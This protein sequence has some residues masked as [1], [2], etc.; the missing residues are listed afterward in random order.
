MHD[1]WCYNADEMYDP[2]LAERYRYLRETEEGREIM[3]KLVED[4]VKEACK[5]TAERVE[6][7]T[8]VR[9]AKETAKKL[10]SLGTLSYE[11]ISETCGLSVGEVEMI[12][13][14]LS[15]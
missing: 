1:F 13:K 9:I 2:V 15:A 11:L 14:E 8:I 10:I 6:K 7:E 3:C 12:A 5:L 4:R